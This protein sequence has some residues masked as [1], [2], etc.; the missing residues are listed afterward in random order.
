MNLFLPDNEETEQRTSLTICQL[1]DGLEHAFQTRL[2]CIYLMVDVWQLPELV[3]LSELLLFCTFCRQHAQL[4]LSRDRSDWHQLI[5]GSPEPGSLWPPRVCQ[6]GKYVSLQ[7]KHTHTNLF[8]LSL[9]SSSIYFV[10]I[11]CHTKLW[12]THYC[13]I[14]LIIVAHICMCVFVGC[15]FTID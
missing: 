6:E 9:F 12:W 8:F 13:P 5:R 10:L 1:K 15:T 14:G 3:L 4:C 7:G 2:I 11:S